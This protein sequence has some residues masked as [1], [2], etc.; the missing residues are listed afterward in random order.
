MKTIFTLYSLVLFSIFSIP[1]TAQINENFNNGLANLSA[2]CWEFPDMMYA[3]TPST[4]VINGNGSLY[5]EPPVSSD[6]VRIVR[7]PFLEVGSTIDI[8]FVY[9]LSSNLNGQA[10]RYI[11]I[12]L[13]N[14]D[15]VVV[16]ALDSFQVT[17]SATTTVSYNQTFAVDI[18]SDYRVAITMGGKTGAGN[19]RLSMDDLYVSAP[20]VGCFA[21]PPGVLPVHL[22][23]FQGNLNK[24]NKVTLN[25]SVADNETVY[26]FEIERSFNG[27]DFTTA[28]VVFAS[29]K[30]GTQ[31]YTFFE[32]VT[33]EKVMYR[34]KMND[35]GHDVDY[36][37]ILIFQ[38]K[39]LNSTDIKVYGN[40]LKDKLTFSYTSNETQI[41]NVRVYDISGKI[42]MNQKV[43]SAEGTN[44]LS[45]PLNP[46]FKAGMYV[47][48]V[49]NGTDSQTA[50]FVKQ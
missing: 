8:A 9:R 40:P 20:L 24:N 22:V 10:T 21:R 26:S 16:Q 1:A 4:N 17:N 37:K 11:K 12:D 34:L 33:G 19:V 49:S 29:E 48:E 46:T 31:S 2:N 35:K 23:S 18:P 44:L 39:S 42:L 5:S 15:N 7:T 41:V 28:G 30:F 43:N 13:V 27:K 47:V 3:T 38:T 45:L 36:S 50:K 25:W 32:T 14:S 6:S